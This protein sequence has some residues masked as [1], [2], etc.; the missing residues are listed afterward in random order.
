MDL[1]ALIGSESPLGRE[2]RDVLTQAGLGKAL[3]LI[4]ASDAEAVLSQKDDEPTVL[5]PLEETELRDAD[6]IVNCAPGGVAARAR[7]M[8]P[9]TPFIDLTGELESEPSARIRCPIVDGEA[10]VAGNPMVIAHPA[11]AALAVLLRRVHRYFPVKHAVVTML[12][13]VSERGTPGIHELQSQ[14]T[15]LLSFK[16]L[17]KDIFDTQVAFNMLPE[18]GDEASVKLGDAASRMES[19]LATLLAGETPMPSVRLLHAPVF[20]GHA[21]SVWIEFDSRPGQ[22]QLEEALASAQI[23]VRGASTEPASNVGV[24]GISGIV[25][26][27]I[28]LDRQH[29]RACWIW[30]AA[31]NYRIAADCALA[32][33]RSILRGEEA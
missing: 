24:A 25:A 1:V 6:V 2:V 30:F 16:P 32:L 33:V 7:S 14:V 17:T 13:P 9:D 29:P 26:G 11:A 31:D 4:G 12:E 21:G 5:S 18:Y 28:E 20:H 23:D 15:S 3:R 8:A 27:P 22:V 10:H 19:N